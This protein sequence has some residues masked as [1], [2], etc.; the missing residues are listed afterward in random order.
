MAAYIALLR[1]VNVGGIKLLMTDLKRLCEEAG[2]TK[3]K[4]FIA[5]GNVV[6]QSRLAEAKVKQ[7]LESR[8]EA[9]MGRAPGVMVRTAAEIAAVLAANPFAE[10]ANNRTVAIFLDHHP[11][12]DALE[13]AT[14]VR[15]EEIRL[16]LREVY[17]FYGGGMADSKLKI[18]TAKT[19]TAR[20]MNTVAKLAAMAAAL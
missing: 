5:S 3:V 14:G 17:V 7:A 6:F 15:D 11:E 20:N 18:P 10:R 12:A 2:F 1:A 16:G 8:L 19:G 13:K 4:T 9:H